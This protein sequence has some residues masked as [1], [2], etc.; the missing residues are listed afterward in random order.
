MD[1]SASIAVLVTMS[2]YNTTMAMYQHSF[3]LP[4]AP[5]SSSWPGVLPRFGGAIRHHEQ[6]SNGQ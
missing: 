6:G 1:D 3:T 4:H 5:S 2:D